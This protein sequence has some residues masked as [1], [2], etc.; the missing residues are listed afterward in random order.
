[1]RRKV[2][3]V[4]IVLE[5]REDALAVGLPLAQLYHWR[6]PEEIEA[7]TAALGAL[8]FVPRTL[9]TPGDVA[10]RLDEVRAGV[11]FVFNISVGFVTRYRMALGPALYSLA[12]L[13]YSGADPYGKMV[14]QNKQLTYG[15]LGAVGVPVPGW[16]YCDDPGEAG[17]LDA[18]AYPVIV[19]PAWEG[20]SIGLDAD[21]VVHD[22]AALRAL[23]RRVMETLR[24]PVVVQRFIRGRELKV[25]ILGDGPTLF[26]GIM[27]DTGGD[28]SPMGDRFLYFDAKKHG[29]FSKRRVDPGDPG[30]AALLADCRRIYRMLAPLD[31]ATF[32]VRVDEAGRH[33]FLEIN[34]DATLHPRRTLA[35]CCRLNGLDYRGLIDAILRS[36][37]ARQD[38]ERA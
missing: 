13:P 20:A 21:A 1:M 3:N 30:M 23:A 4:G 31:Y 32:D 7:V 25:G 6:E 33:H 28:G 35:E 18:P 19:K 10:R 27:E 36:A 8:G 12:G 37:F 34:A 29:A 24:M 17:R 26:E 9:G 15:L 16:Q 2:R 38:L 14:S 11:D 22:A 5:T